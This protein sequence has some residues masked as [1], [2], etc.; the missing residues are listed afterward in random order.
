MQHV[1]FVQNH[2]HRAGAQTCLAR[3]L[4]HGAAG[5]WEPVL[6][7]SPGGW[8]PGE[9]ARLGIAVIE[10][11]FPSSRS[12]A[13]R[14][15]GNAA[16][17]RNVAQKLDALGLRP[18]IVHAND[19]TEGLL[20]LMLASRFGARSAIF[21]RSSGMSKQDYFKYRCDN[22][23]L[24]IA[25]GDGLRRSAQSWD[26]NKRILLIHDGIGEEEFLDAKAKLPAAPR[27]VLV[28]GNAGEAK[29]WGDLAAA[30]AKLE[31][32]GWSLPAFDFT[33]DAAGKAYNSVLQK[34]NAECRFLG[35]IDAFRDLVR[36]YDLV[37][38]PSRNESFGMA[39][40]E[41]LA[42]GV[43]LVSS[44]TGVIEQVIERPDILFPPTRPEI[45]A[46]TLGHVLTHWEQIDFGVERAQTNIR[47]RFLIDKAAAGLDDAYDR[48]LAEKC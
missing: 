21:L 25:A 28:I 27:R 31:A 39:A 43:P 44:R 40:I 30:L 36:G 11:T 37:I 5:A 48:L 20:G 29:G 10:Q 7:C 6:L 8:L 33:G 45:L 46:E 38:N 24:V 18:A 16:F 1:L 26:K 3:L 22:Y 41:V 9:C 4:R 14:L 12:L 2:T 19:H 15:F 13:G 42:A 34:L 17:A 23:D 35:R 32:I 47:G